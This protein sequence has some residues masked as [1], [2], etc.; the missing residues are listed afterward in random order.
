[1]LVYTTQ[2]NS[3]FRARCLASSE[4]ISQRKAKWLSVSDK[5]TLKQVKLLFGPLVIQLVW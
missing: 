1:M 2:V 4:M 3:A 5:V